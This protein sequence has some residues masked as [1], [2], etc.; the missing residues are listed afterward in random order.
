VVERVTSMDGTSIAFERLGDGPPLVM[1]GGALSDRRAG[2]PIAEELA[3]SLTAIAV[4]RRGRGDSGDT[5]PFAVQ[6]EVEDVLAILDAVG[7]G[8]HVLGHSSGAVLTLEVARTFPDAVTSLAL[9]EPPFILDGG[10]APLP[11]DFVDRLEELAATGRR[12]DA[13]AYFLGTAVG[14]PDAAVDA[15]RRDPSWTDMTALAHTLHYDARIVRDTTTA[16]SDQL[17]RW[18][19]VKVPT[20]VMDG[21]ASP[22]WIRSSA[23]ALAATLPDATPR[24]LEGQ[25]HGPDPSVYASELRTWVEARTA[26][27]SHPA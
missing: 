12:D 15:A 21:G 13:V 4:D 9:Y 2:R 6:R 19:T 25:G 18:A 7:G 24:T 3:P 23:A 5:Q 1:I 20:L 8:G 10:R 14:L 16:E 22:P 17:G 11:D 27:R 26:D